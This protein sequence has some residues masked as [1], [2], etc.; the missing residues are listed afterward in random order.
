MD[1]RIW[2]DLRVSTRSCR[3]APVDPRCGAQEGRHRSRHALPL[4]T[5]A[6]GF[7]RS[8]LSGRAK[9][10]PMSSRSR[11]QACRRQ[12]CRRQVSRR[13]VSRQGSVARMTT[14]AASTRPPTDLQAPG[15]RGRSES[16]HACDLSRPATTIR[17]IARYRVGR[18]RRRSGSLR[19]LPTR[20][21]SRVRRSRRAPSRR[22]HGRRW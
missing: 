12:V 1:S 14:D 17:A 13:Q 8:G 16:K 11:R 10:A 18:T 5:C 9:R 15:R 20:V 2:G 3:P 6:S 19:L 7:P 4:K 21:R 22:A